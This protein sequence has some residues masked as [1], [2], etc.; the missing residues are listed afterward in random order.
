VLYLISLGVGKNIL[1]AK[2]YGER[3]PKISAP[4]K[5]EEHAMNRRVEFEIKKIYR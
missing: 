4:L 2:G 5:E 3:K 1:R